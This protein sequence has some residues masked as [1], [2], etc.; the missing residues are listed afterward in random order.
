MKGPIA[1]GALALLW[2]L[3]CD[4]ATP[5]RPDPRQRAYALI[6]EQQAESA[7]AAGDVVLLENALAV[8]QTKFESLPPPDTQTPADDLAVHLAWQLF[9]YRLRALGT[10]GD[11]NLY[12]RELAQLAC[13]PA[14]DRLAAV[15][16]SF[17]RLFQAREL[18]A[19]IR[20]SPGSRTR[21]TP[22]SRKPSKATRRGSPW[23][24]PRSR[25]ASLPASRSRWWT[26]R[27]STRAGGRRRSCGKR[28]RHSTPA[29]WPSSR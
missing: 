27:P 6:D 11:T 5:A 12:A 25:R 20:R 15:R 4:A 21:S 24:R 13:F 8:A 18:M 1:V 19:A 29:T 7:L 10:G 14:P 23:R 16:L 28:V 9:W 3:P 2:A 17:R 26:P 22:T